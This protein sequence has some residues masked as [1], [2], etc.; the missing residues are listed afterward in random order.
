[1][2]FNME[3]DNAKYTSDVYKQAATDAQVR[4]AKAEEELAELH[5]QAQ[6]LEIEIE[7]TEQEEFSALPDDNNA[8]VKYDKDTE[9]HQVNLQNHVK[10]TDI[11]IDNNSKE[12]PDKDANISIDNSSKETLDKDTDITLDNNSKETPDKEANISIDNSSKETLDKDTDITLDNNSKETP[13]KE[14]N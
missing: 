14:A 2:M 10:V 5:K 1:M 9:E 4:A 11:F 7:K 8:P 12:T 13:D 3:K 6:Q